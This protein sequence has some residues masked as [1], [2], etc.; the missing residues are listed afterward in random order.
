M[1]G[2]PESET[3]EL[4][5]E[6][7]ATD[8]LRAGDAMAKC[9]LAIEGLEENRKLANERAKKRVQTQVDRRNELAHMIATGT[10]VRDVRCVW[11]EDF[12]HNV[13]RLIRQDT[14]DEVDTRAMTAADRQTDLLGGPELER[15]GGG[16][17]ADELNALDILEQ[18]A[19]LEDGNDKD[20]GED[21]EDDD[22]QDDDGED[23]PDPPAR[24]HLDPEPE[25]LDA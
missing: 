12:A 25:Q 15:D 18:D 1:P 10:E 7:T 9:E 4:P 3:R 20:D 2:Q 21:G 17:G 13:H 16:P 11:I 19:V 24:K 6:L 14:G 23:P 8:L 22:E 5:C